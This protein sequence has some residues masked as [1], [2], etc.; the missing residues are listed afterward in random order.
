M[1]KMSLHQ[2]CEVYKKSLVREHD[3]ND[4]RELRAVL[5]NVRLEKEIKY[6]L[7]FLE[8]KDYRHKPC[9]AI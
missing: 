4:S 7:G 3:Y 2:A 9:K 5:K 1:S 6:Q 8:K